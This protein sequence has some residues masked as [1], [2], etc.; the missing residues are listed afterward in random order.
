MDPSGAPME[1]I[2]PR[3]PITLMVLAAEDI[4]LDAAPEEG[5]A[6]DMAAVRDSLA[7]SEKRV[8]SAEKEVAE[9]AQ[10]VAQI[11][12]ELQR[13]HAVEKTGPD[14]EKLTRELA[15]AEGLLDQ[16]K[17]RLAKLNAKAEDAK[18]AAESLGVEADE[19]GDGDK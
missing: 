12:T 4:D 16:A 2:L 14:A 10:S 19:N 11:H 7:D 3:L 17:R 8:R 5:L 13:L 9:A 18:K 1:R 6:G 15:D